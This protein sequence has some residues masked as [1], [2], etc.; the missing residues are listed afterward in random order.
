MARRGAFISNSN[1]W[2]E[3]AR[4]VYLWRQRGGRSARLR[5]RKRRGSE[6]KK[7]DKRGGGILI[8]QYQANGI[9]GYQRSV[10]GNHRKMSVINVAA[11]GMA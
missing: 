3:T 10:G 11:A 6:R 5:K 8:F 4:N 1:A 7:N 2:R 9:N